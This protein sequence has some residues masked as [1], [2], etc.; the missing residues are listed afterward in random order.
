MGMSEGR[1]DPRHLMAKILV[2]DDSVMD[3][4]LAGKLLEKRSGWAVTSA[5]NGQAG[6]AALERETFDLVL[7]D[8]QMPEMNGLEL[9]S[10][11]RAQ[12]TYVPVILMT[13]H[14]SEEIAMQALQRGAA[15]Y[16]PKQNLARDLIDT[17]ENVLTVASA[18]RNQQRLLECLMRT[19]SQF[20]L[21]NDPSLI[22]PL[23]GHVRENLLR[24]NMCDETGLIRVTMALSE[25]LTM[26]IVQGNLQIDPTLRDLDEKAYQARIDERRRQKPYRDRRIHVTAKELLHEARYVIRHEGPGIDVAA[27]PEPEGPAMFDTVATRGLLLIRTFMDE[28]THNETGNEMTLTKRRDR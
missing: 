28:V 3:R 18:E 13:A 15:S 26:A 4:T 20:M 24:M 6:L 22:P 16:V 23:I 5:E 7:S 19:E 1:E 14:G 10:A 25:A 12:H 17:V 27:L 11:I 21:D 9:V 2:V 8:L